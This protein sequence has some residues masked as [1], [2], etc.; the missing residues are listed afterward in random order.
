MVN[1]ILVF[2][3]WMAFKIIE[4]VSHNGY[5]HCSYLTLLH[6]TPHVLLIVL[7]W[8]IIWKFPPFFIPLWNASIG[9]LFCLLTLPFWG[10]IAQS[11]KWQKWSNDREGSWYDY[12]LPHL[13]YKF[14]NSLHLPLPHH[15]CAMVSISCPLVTRCRCYHMTSY[16]VH[17]H[18]VSWYL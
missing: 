1:N 16:I 13:S 10:P 4:I 15:S 11:N 12:S 6:M 17:P 5:V 3:A 7:S 18:R 2:N 8:L 9:S 14:S